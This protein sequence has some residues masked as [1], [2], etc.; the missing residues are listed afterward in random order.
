L[1]VAFANEIGKLCAQM[2]M[3]G[4]TVMDVF[5]KDSKLNIS[6]SYLRPGFAFGGSCL[7]KDVRALQ[8]AGR[9]CDI[10]LPLMAGVLESNAGIIRDSVQAVLDSG[11]RK[12]ALLGLSF[13]KNTDDLRESPFVEAAEQLIG[14]GIELKIY[15]PNVSVAR[16][17]GANMEFINR[18]IPHL[19]RLLV[20][21]LDE[22]VASVDLVILGHNYP[23][24]ENLQRTDVPFHILDLTGQMRFVPRSVLQMA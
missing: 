13:K 16:L 1:K 10:H 21:S 6:R 20:G 7:P 14:K 24:V 4:E 3:N 12:V 11:A 5:C 23:G 18:S 19:A 15:D 22:A 2:G 9:L 17:T 8:Y